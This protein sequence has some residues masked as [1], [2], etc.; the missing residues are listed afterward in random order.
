VPD[1]PVHEGAANL[2]VVC[3]VSDGQLDRAS[4]E[5]LSQA[6]ALAPALGGGVG[7]LVLTATAGR[8]V[9]D[10][11]RHG[12]DVVYLAEDPSLADYLTEPYARV[13]AGAVRT[14]QPSALLLAATTTGRDLAPRVASL[15]G[16]G[17]AADCT[18]LYVDSWTRLGVTHEGL[19]HMVR[20]AMAGG[21]LATCLCPEARPQMAT[22]RPGVFGVRLARRRPRVVHLEVVPV[23]AD[24]R[25]E[26]IERHISP[27]DVDLREADVVI[28]GGAGCDASSWH[29]VEELAEAIGGRVAASRGAV[30]AGLAERAQQVGQTGATI[31]PK[32]YVACGISGALQHA[33]G[34]QNSGT[35]VAI[36]RDPEAVVFRLA[37]FGIVADV[38]DAI[39][40]LV[41][42]LTA[43]RRPTPGSGRTG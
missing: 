19:L 5:L 11:G 32:L 9:E 36:N 26:L 42:A 40:Q 37:H 41:A 34:M 39:P 27:A 22:V 29:L 17:L 15:L 35:I 30:E 18:D 25:V 28:A 6:T 12:A 10:A 13:V 24:R 4:R 14:H 43:T 8:A 21:V 38:R 20:P 1:G 31:R 23:P 3:Q 33:V 16:T 7:A 2:W